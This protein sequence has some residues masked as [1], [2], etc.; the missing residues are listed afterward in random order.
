M[1]ETVRG[2]AYRCGVLFECLQ[3]GKLPTAQGAPTR[4]KMLSLNDNQLNAV[5]AGATDLPPDKRAAYLERVAAHLQI[6]C[7]RFNDEDVVS[8]VQMARNGLAQK[9]SA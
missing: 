9:A 4:L 5:V 7:G 6:R 2:Q 3:A 1:P 8:A